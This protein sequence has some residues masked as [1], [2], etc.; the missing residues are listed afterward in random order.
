MNDVDLL[1]RRALIYK[2][3]VKL[4]EELAADFPDP[5]SVPTPPPPSP[6][7]TVP[8]AQEEEPLAEDTA[9]SGDEC[10][11]VVGGLSLAKPQPEAPPPT[12]GPRKLRPPPGEGL[13]KTEAWWKTN[14]LISLGYRRELKAYQIARN[15]VLASGG[16]DAM[17]QPYVH[18]VSEA[19]QALKAA[20]LVR[21]KGSGK[22]QKWTLTPAGK[23]QLEALP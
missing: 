22:D 23:A 8:P 15:I 17:V 3:V 20:K 5:P 9:A 21:L 2:G 6:P 1:L 19:C 4:L 13:P 12:T 14:T 18:K 10:D 11:E 7:V 16:T